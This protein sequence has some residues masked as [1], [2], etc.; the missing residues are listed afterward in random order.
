M[1]LFPSDD[2]QYAAIYAT[3]AAMVDASELIAHALET[4]GMTQADL[5]RKLNV[6]PSEITS[7]LRGERNITV[8]S[9]AK[10][11][12][13]LGQELELRLVPPVTAQEEPY[14]RWKAESSR[15]REDAKSQSHK[16]S[17]SE[18]AR[19]EAR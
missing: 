14:R 1:G 13:A 10:T 11:L 17:T 12:H 15:T 7:R 9:L 4:S 19:V 18:W 16:H 2:P 5:A 6:S 3:E 8:S